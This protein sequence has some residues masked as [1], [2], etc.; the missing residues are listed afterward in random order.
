MYDSTMT[1]GEQELLSARMAQAI[2]DLRQKRFATKQAALA[3]IY[4]AINGV[5]TLGN[6][7]SPLVPIP[8]F[9]P[10]TTGNLTKNFSV[11][12]QDCAAII[13][14]LLGTENDASGLYNSFAAAQN[15]L[16]QAIRER[17]VASS[18]RTY[19]EA[20]INDS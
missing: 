16:R 1:A 18:S 12:N 4:S 7:M 2:N 17:L 15:V 13:E 3:E 5:L 20:F 19:R 10:A 14:Q 9:G 6:R 8:A 11:L